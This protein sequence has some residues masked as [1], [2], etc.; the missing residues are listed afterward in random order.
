MRAGVFEM[1]HMGRV[2]GA[3]IHGVD[4]ARD[5]PEFAE[6][7]TAGR[8]AAP[9]SLSPLAGGTQNVSCNAR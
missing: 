3:E 6:S 4:L 8:P 7:T 2:I 1:S 9:V 5:L